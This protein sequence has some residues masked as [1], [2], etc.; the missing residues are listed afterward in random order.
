MLIS[1]AVC[2]YTAR[3]SKAN[4]NWRIFSFHLQNLTVRAAQPPLSLSNRS[5]ADLCAN[6]FQ[7]D[8]A[9]GFCAAKAFLRVQNF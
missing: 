7:F 8:P 2:D 1:L 9:H 3:D 4:F 5:A 6:A